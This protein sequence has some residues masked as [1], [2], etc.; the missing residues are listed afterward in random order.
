[1]GFP[2]M[3]HGAARRAH[4]FDHAP[5]VDEDVTGECFAVADR[6]GIGTGCEVPACSSGPF[7]PEPQDPAHSCK[8]APDGR[9]RIVERAARTRLVER[10]RFDSC[11]QRSQF[12][13]EVRCDACDAVARAEKGHDL[14]DPHQDTRPRRFRSTRRGQADRERPGDAQ[15]VSARLSARLNGPSTPP[16]RPRAPPASRPIRSACGNSA[17]VRRGSALPAGGRPGWSRL[18]HARPVPPRPRHDAIREDGRGMP[19][20]SL[21]STGRTVRRIRRP[22]REPLAAE[23]QDRADHEPGATSK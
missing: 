1:M 19:S 6:D 15:R 16:R 2:R 3:R 9:I 4:R 11:A 21:P 20:P 17:P 18:R 10:E 13:F 5:V 23:H 12:L 22:G 14:N 8:T 7:E